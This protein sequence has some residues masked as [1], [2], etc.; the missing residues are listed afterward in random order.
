MSEMFEV[1]RE[2]R[3]TKYALRGRQRQ[4]GEKRRVMCLLAMG[5]G[6]S[7]RI[8]GAKRDE[9]TG[10]MGQA[11]YKTRVC[12]CETKQTRML[13]SRSYVRRSLHRVN[14][15][16]AMIAQSRRAMV[17]TGRVA[18]DADVNEVSAVHVRDRPRVIAE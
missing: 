2:D 6:Q 8:L 11:E 12:V 14:D 17:G 7:L 9:H 4:E 10:V 13:M 3:L 5:S 18:C 15:L 16:R 1:A